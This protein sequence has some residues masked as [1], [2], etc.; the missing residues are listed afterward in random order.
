MTAQLRWRDRARG[1]TSWPPLIPKGSL[2]LRY[3]VTARITYAAVIQSPILTSPRQA[4]ALAPHNNGTRLR[5]EAERR[6]P[7]WF[8]A[9]RE[10][11]EGV[12]N[13]WEMFA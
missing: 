3:A 5:V 1:Q 8:Y 2:S 7:Q 9:A 10:L 4:S 13:I 6:Y 11:F 12:L